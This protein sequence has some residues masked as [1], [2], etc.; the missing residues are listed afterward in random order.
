MPLLASCAEI[1]SVDA[2]CEA[3]AA[4]CLSSPLI[5]HMSATGGLP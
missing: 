3:P 2:D 4:G 5:G 1:T